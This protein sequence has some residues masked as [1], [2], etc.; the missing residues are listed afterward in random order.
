MKGDFMMHFNS[1]L[2]LRYCDPASEVTLLDEIETLGEF[3]FGHCDSLVSVNL[4]PNVSHFEWMVFSYST[5]LKTI[6]IPSSLTCLG[7]GCFNGCS[8]LQ[9][10]LFVPDSKLDC[11]PGTAFSCCSL[12]ETIILPQYVK[13]LGSGCFMDCRKLVRSPIPVNSEIVRIE[14]SAFS[15]CSRLKSILLPSTLEFDDRSCF[16]RCTS[17][18]TFTS[19]SRSHLKVL[20][21]LPPKLAGLLWVPDSV[22]I[23]AF[24]KGFKRRLDRALIFGGDSRL[25]EI[26]AGSQQ[27]QGEPAGKGKKSKQQMDVQLFRR[28]RVIR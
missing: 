18:S 6:T 22:E 14:E 5:S 10:V 3:C 8:A 1:R 11:I 19:V 16:E 2:L 17:P 23:L 25:G 9:L 20:L 12:L 7:V 15:G 28:F 4:G 26:M 24:A 21:D 13:L 27:S